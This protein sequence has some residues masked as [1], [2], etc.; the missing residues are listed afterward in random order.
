[1][2]EDT[3]A[4]LLNFIYR[5]EGD[6]HTAELKEHLA[7]SD[8]VLMDAIEFLERH[9]L[10]ESIDDGYRLTEKGFDVARDR[11]MQ[12]SQLET[13][14][15]LA[16]FTFM[17]TL[18]IVVQTVYQLLDLGQPGMIAGGLLIGSVLLLFGLLE[19]R[20]GLFRMVLSGR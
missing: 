6:P 2:A 16:V 4:K 5:N 19:R 13:N 14:M 17:L 8:A 20:T 7:V 11:E 15:H 9:Q 12:L 10:V 1:M 18:A 3:W